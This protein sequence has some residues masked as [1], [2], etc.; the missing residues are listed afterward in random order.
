MTCQQDWKQKKEMGCNCL[1]LIDWELLSAGS[2]PLKRTRLLKAHMIILDYFI[3]FIL[4]Y[5]LV[6]TFGEV[7]SE[8]D[9]EK[10]PMMFAWKP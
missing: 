8:E 3:Y 9:D 2:L 1:R 6:H 10:G 7:D 5:I 4:K